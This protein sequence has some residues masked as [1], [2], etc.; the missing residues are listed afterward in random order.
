MAEQEEQTAPDEAAPQDEAAPAASTEAPSEEASAEDASAGEASAGEA[1]AGDGPTD[2]E[3]S[4]G[5]LA[6]AEEGAGVVAGQA[7]V[8]EDVLEADAEE[9]HLRK[10]RVGVVES[11]KME[12]TI[13]VSIE[14][15]RKHPMYKK[16]LKRSARKMVH[17]ENNDAGEGDTV[18][19][20]ETRPLSKH[21]RWRLVDILER[22]K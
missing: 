6:L 20:V 11:A 5:D 15:Q 17:D 1:S 4:G 2:A 12:K 19:I 14:R 13:V 7:A 18:R 3:D 22:A 9:R 10:E 8:D 21:K 16:Y